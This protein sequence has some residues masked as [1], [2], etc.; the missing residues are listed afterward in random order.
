MAEKSTMDKLKKLLLRRPA[1]TCEEAGAEFG[2]SK[3][4]ISQ[5]ARKAGF[6]KV[7][8]WVLNV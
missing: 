5:L 2:V 8:I 6:R 3:Q 4:R 7:T 1:T